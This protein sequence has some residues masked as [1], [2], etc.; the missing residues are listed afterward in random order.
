MSEWIRHR[1]SKSMP[2][3]L[4]G[5]EFEVRMRD[6]TIVPAVGVNDWKHFGLCED[7]MAFRTIG[8]IN[9]HDYSKG[10]PVGTTAKDIGA[11]VGD[12]FVVVKKGMFQVG[13]IVT[14]D[15]DDCS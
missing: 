1:G 4:Q 13:E 9:P 15:W 8:D 12:E 11:K 14:L 2:K 7:I 6:G 10:F 3:C 5:K